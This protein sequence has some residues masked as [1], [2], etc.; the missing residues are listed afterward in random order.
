MTTPGN[1]YYARFAAPPPPPP[2]PTRSALPAVSLAISA[3]ALLGV[4]ILTASLALSGA[5]SSGN[6]AP[7][8]SQLSPAPSGILSGDT[9]SNALTDVIGED[10]GDVSDLRCPETPAV[11]QGVTTL[12]HG[13][14]SGAAWAIAVFFEDDQGRYTALP[15]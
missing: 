6:D 15:M 13:T 3:L 14:I 12:C 9:L 11:R 5:F 4:I 2:T 7:L 8:T 1:P 10:G